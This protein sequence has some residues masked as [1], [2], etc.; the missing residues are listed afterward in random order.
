MTTPFESSLFTVAELQEGGEKQTESRLV[1]PVYQRPFCWT[2]KQIEVLVQ[3][4]IT[5]FVRYDEDRSCRYSLGT[6]VC[7]QRYSQ[8][9]LGESYPDGLEVVDGQ[10][11]LTCIDVILAVLGKRVAQS[12]PEYVVDE[13]EFTDWIP[14]LIHKYENITEE[15]SEESFGPRIDRKILEKICTMI[16]R[17]VNDRCDSEETRRALV[18]KFIDCIRKSVC[19]LRVTLPVDDRNAYEGPAMFEI[20]NMRGQALSS[21]DIAK[22]LLAEKLADDPERLAFDRLWTGIASVLH[23]N[24]KTGEVKSIVDDMSKEIGDTSR[25][26]DPNGKKGII[27]FNDIVK[28]ALEDLQSK[29]KQRTGNEKS[30]ISD[31]QRFIVDFE[32]LFLIANEVF[33]RIKCKNTKYETLNTRPRPG[34]KDYRS[35]HERMVVGNDF[36]NEN[37]DKDDRKKEEDRNHNN[38]KAKAGEQRKDVWQFMSVLLIAAMVACQANEIMDAQSESKNPFALLLDTFYAA[39]GYQYSGQY[40][41]LSLVHTAVKV[42][43]PDDRFPETVEAFV[44]EYQPTPNLEEQVKNSFKQGYLRLL[45]WGL[46][47][48]VAPIEAEKM[49]ARV[50]GLGADQDENKLMDDTKLRREIVGRFV[51]IGQEKAPFSAWRYTE[52][53][54]RWKL[55]FTDWLLWVDFKQKSDRRFSHLESQLHKH[56]GLFKDFLEIE[57]S[58]NDPL[59]AF[60]EDFES[61]VYG[62]DQPDKMR[63]V[64]RSQ[65][66][67]WIAQDTADLVGRDELHNFGNLA[68]INTSENISNG[69]KSTSDKSAP[70]QLGSNPTAKLLWLS[71][72]AKAGAN[73]QVELFNCL[74]KPEMTKFWVDYIGSFADDWQTS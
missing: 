71:I 74:C 60:R 29:Y 41:L 2:D 10:Q 36:R 68:L 58:K 49:T 53:G 24:S 14:T 57:G 62:K 55:F 45:L 17:A 50:L 34:Q 69:N 5:H 26:P 15:K 64:S 23:S 33:R 63:I 16:N 9:D 37:A 48:F 31:E 11:R 12:N 54:I 43:Y 35:L 30:K 6:V 70:R 56:S 25:A 32:N 20:V 72:F 22:A 19:V 46:E 73:E 4:L 44:K 40:W 28:E 39:N 59:K 51:L 42:I 52:N 13:D 3:D 65:I 67:H 1:V 61:K 27:K 7:H 47:R 21:I 66:E 18:E 8:K 38:D